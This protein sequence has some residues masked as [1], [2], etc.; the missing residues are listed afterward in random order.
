VKLISL[1]ENAIVELI[2]ADAWRIEEL[3]E[4]SERE[5]LERM[6]AAG[7]NVSLAFRLARA[8]RAA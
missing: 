6:V 3:Y 8:A 5:I 4:A 7:V 2:D 1:V